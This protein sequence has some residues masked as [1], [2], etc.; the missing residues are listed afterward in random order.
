MAQSEGVFEKGL[1]DGAP[2][3]L[4]LTVTAA[5]GWRTA[6]AESE[7]GERVTRRKR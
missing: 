2:H 4:A 3:A 6:R 1:D 5:R 7:A